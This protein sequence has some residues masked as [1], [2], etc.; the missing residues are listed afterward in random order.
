[1]LHHLLPGHEVDLVLHY[2]NFVYTG[3][4]E[5]MRCSFVCGWGQG[6]LA[7]MTSTAPS[8]IAAPQSIVAMRVSCLRIYEGYSSQDLSLAAAMRHFSTV[9]AW[10]RQLGHFLR[11]S[12]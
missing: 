1:M 6:S 7:E 2:H 9:N 11:A 10:I 8:M 5:A 4:V 12:A 3:D